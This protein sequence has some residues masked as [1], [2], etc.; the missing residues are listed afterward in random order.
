MNYREIIS[1]SANVFAR[2]TYNIV[3]FRGSRRCSLGLESSINKALEQASLLLKLFLLS[4]KEAHLLASFI[5]DSNLDK[6]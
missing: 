3:T 4:G 1:N 5:D 2:I 6:I